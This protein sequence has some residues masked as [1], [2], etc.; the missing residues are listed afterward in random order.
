MEKRGL[1]A[2]TRIQTIVQKLSG[3]KNVKKVI[4]DIQNVTHDLQT[5]LQKLSADQAVKRYKDL[6][7]KVVTAENELSR[8]VTKVVAQVKKSATD[9]EKNLA[10]YKKKAKAQRTKLEKVIRTK[11][12][13]YGVKTQKAVKAKPTAKK[14]KKKVARRSSK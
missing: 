2:L 7:K 14:A 13:K 3:Q 4:A 10:N 8:E 12:A 1:M 11:A 6:A 5:K 9:V